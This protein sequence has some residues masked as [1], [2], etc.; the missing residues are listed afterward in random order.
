MDLEIRWIYRIGGIAAI[1]Q[2]TLTLIIIVVS[3]ALGL[4][5]STAEEYFALY[6]SNRIIGLLRDDFTSL[7]II[8]LYLFTFYSLYLALKREKS[9]YVTFLTIL[10]FVG[11]ICCFATHSGISMIHLSDK[12][13]SATTEVQ[14]S[15]LIS[16][17]EAVIASG[18]WNSTAGFI[19]GILLQGVGVLI[20]IVMLNNKVFRKLTIFSGLLANGLDLIQHLITPI[21]MPLGNIFLMI[22]GPF[23]LI[24]FLMLGLDLLR[25]SK[26]NSYE[27]A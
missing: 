10:V 22:A 26:M 6:E 17:G 12:Y 15:Q 2:F 21:F 19:A 18:M 11:V 16:A 13:A 27:R 7:F 9:I 1:L 25:L 23:Y 4:K 5:P 3:S 8:A 20:S 24:W 14:R